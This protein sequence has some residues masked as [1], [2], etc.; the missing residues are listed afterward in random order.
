ML[1]SG[2]KIRFYFGLQSDG[3]PFLSLLDD[4]GNIRAILNVSMQ[5]TAEDISP[6]LTFADDS[7]E[8]R[9][10]I[11]QYGGKEPVMVFINEQGKT[12]VILREQEGRPALAL[13]DEF[14]TTR[15]VFQLGPDGSPAL[16]IQDERGRAIR[17]LP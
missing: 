9:F 3:S 5:A 8:P 13:L 2:G 16:I 11:L 10:Q 1:D 4:A 12:S 17:R 14:G 7:G 15:G 6:S